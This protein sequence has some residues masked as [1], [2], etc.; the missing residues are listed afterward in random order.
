MRQACHSVSAVICLRNPEL[1]D[2]INA[3][4]ELLGL[5]F[6]S[7]AFQGKESLLTATLAV[8]VG[9]KIRLDA[10]GKLECWSVMI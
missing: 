3:E 7:L 10:V 4:L 8:P 1:R 6:E 2:K 5:D 9:T